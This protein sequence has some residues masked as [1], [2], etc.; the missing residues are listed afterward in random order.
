MTAH[1]FNDSDYKIK[2]EVYDSTCLLEFGYNIIVYVANKVSSPSYVDIQF[3]FSDLANSIEVGVGF[4]SLVSDGL[5]A[6]LNSFK[7][8]G[9]I[10]PSIVFSLVDFGLMST[11]GYDLVN[12][13]VV[14]YV[15]IWCDPST[16]YLD[17]VLDACVDD[18]G[19]GNYANTLTGMCES[20]YQYC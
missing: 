7:Y 9:H 5:I 3:R 10:V 19:Q 1:Y 8:G 4:P 17:L 15:S 11:Y 6:G 2:V 13:T 12:I 16:P 18:C 20:C 14:Q